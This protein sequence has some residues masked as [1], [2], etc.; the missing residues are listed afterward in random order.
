MKRRLVAALT[1]LLAGVIV[2][3][4]S[5]VTAA[6]ELIEATPARV[7]IAVPAPGHSA[8][9]DMSVSNLTDTEYP[10]TLHVSGASDRLFGG[11]HPLE[12]ELTDPRTGDVIYSGPAG[13]SIDAAIL[14]P[15]L[16]ARGEYQLAG[17]LSM[18]RDAG[19]EYQAASGQMVF[20]F[21][22]LGDDEPQRPPTIP[23]TGSDVLFWALLGGIGIVSGIAIV[24]HGRK[25][26][27]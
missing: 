22:V 26:T 14:V 1:A 7:S 21:R 27:S 24:A 6:D 13:E 12:L 19:N 10:L 15:P 4:P 2:F 20:E 5:A 9:W 16:P 17:T 8:Q 11:A 3:T 25:K 18:P 23:N